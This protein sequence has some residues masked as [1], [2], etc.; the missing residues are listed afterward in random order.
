MIERSE[1]ESKVRELE[2]AIDDTR[3]SLKNRA[4]L[5]AISVVI[6]IGVAFVIGR[7]RGRTRST[8]V[9]IYEL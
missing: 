5:V 9:E 3:E 8:I 2:A 7:R 4:V 1:I 6:V